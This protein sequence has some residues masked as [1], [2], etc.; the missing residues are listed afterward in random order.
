MIKDIFAKHKFETCAPGT[1]NKHML[2]HMNP[3]HGDQIMN[4][5]KLS[6]KGKV[7]I[8]VHEIRLADDEVKYIFIDYIKGPRVIDAFYDV[9]NDVDRFDREVSIILKSV[10]GE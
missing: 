10:G 1:F 4:S 2:A 8:Y 3:A 9:E 5:W 6:I 7:S